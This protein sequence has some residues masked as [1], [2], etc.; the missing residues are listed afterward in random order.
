MMPRR[1][2]ETLTDS[3][4]PL[5]TTAFCFVVEGHTEHDYLQ[6]A[7][8]VAEPN[9]IDNPP[10]TDASNLIRNALIHLGK[11]SGYKK[12]FV[13]FDQDKLQPDSKT[14]ETIGKQLVDVRDEE[15]VI[16]YSAPWFDYILQL[17]FD[18]N[19]SVD[20]DSKKALVK[21][22]FGKHKKEKTRQ[23]LMEHLKK[24]SC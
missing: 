3:T 10:C 20:M 22:G 5:Q 6:I 9:I 21:Y 13:V 24:T 18:N 4:I 19:P 1:P 14:W 16:L 8:G 17:H 11:G 12:I 7:L 15:I 2:V 23:R